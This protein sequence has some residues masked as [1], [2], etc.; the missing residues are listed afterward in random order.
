MA[1]RINLARS[2]LSGDGRACIHTTAGLSRQQ[3]SV[4]QQALCS[5]WPG[6]ELA[7]QMGQELG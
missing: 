3:I 4:A 5:L 6:D 7:P 2:G 1:R